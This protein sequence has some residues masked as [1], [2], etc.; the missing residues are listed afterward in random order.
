MTSAALLVATAIAV[1]LDLDLE[2]QV[3]GAHD[4]RWY[5][6]QEDLEP[7]LSDALATNFTGLGWSSDL[8]APLTGNLTN[9]QHLYLDAFHGSRLTS[10]MQPLAVALR[11]ACSGGDGGSAGGEGRG[12]GVGM[13]TRPLRILD[14]EGSVIEDQGTTELSPALA[15]CPTLTALHAPANRIGDVGARALATALVGPPPHPGLQVLDL[16]ANRIGDYGADGLAMLLRL[17]AAEYVPVPLI[18]LRLHDNRIGGHGTQLLAQ[19]LRDNVHLETLMLS[20]NPIGDEGASWLAHALVSRKPGRNSVMRKLF[21][22][23][24]NLTDAG[25]KALQGALEQPH[26]PVLDTLVLDGNPGLSASA[27]ADLEDAVR[28]RQPSGAAGTALY[29]APPSDTKATGMFVQ[30]GGHRDAAP[31]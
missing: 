9:C 16:H 4:G 8:V 18:E 28:R 12:G 1:L 5:C 23:A 3:I 6:L 25:A 27:R 17:P 26:A 21:L 24:T 2:R 13:G 31:P 11:A 14:L 10:S 22:A 15:H 30:A 29:A 20:G 7:A 19:S